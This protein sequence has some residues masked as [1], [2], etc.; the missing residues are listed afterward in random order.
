MGLKS[1][2]IIKLITIALLYTIGALMK[3]SGLSSTYRT[4]QKRTNKINTSTTLQNQHFAAKEKQKLLLK[5]AAEAQFER[6]K[7]EKQ[8][9]DDQSI[10]PK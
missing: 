1:I 10:S 8:A 6:Q 2:E 7:R 5:Q 9:L 3:S 4:M